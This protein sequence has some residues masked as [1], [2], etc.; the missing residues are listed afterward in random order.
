[1][2]LIEEA[3]YCTTSDARWKA[4]LKIDES[5][6]D[7]FILAILNAQAEI[8]SFLYDTYAVPFTYGNIPP[9]IRWLCSDLAASIILAKVY[10]GMSPNETP[11][12][13]ILFDKSMAQLKRLAEGEE[14][15]PGQVV[16]NSTPSIITN[17]QH[18]MAIFDLGPYKDA[19]FVES[20]HGMDG[21]ESVEGID[22]LGIY[23]Y[24][25]LLR[26]IYGC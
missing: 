6:P 13:K 26:A 14:N 7:D 1:M 5:S 20:V 3:Y 18:T 22:G 15:L 11:Y 8:D 21:L 12:G 17:T 25:S 2:D 19:A 4:N 24:W 10:T 23:D 9:K 16:L